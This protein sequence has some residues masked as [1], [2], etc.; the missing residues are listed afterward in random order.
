MKGRA[1]GSAGKLRR[2]VSNRLSDTGGL[3]G[4]LGGGD[5]QVAL[6]GVRDGDGAVVGE[7]LVVGLDGARVVEVVDHQPGGLA[8]AFGRGVAGPVQALEAGAVAEVEARDRVDRPRAGTL[9]AEV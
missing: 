7:G 9:G 3:R 5:G 1:A 6:H 4:V 2:K 8:Q